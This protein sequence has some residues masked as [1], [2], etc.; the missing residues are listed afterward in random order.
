MST[1]NQHNG[2]RKIIGGVLWNAVQ[3]L[4][5]QAFSIIIRLVLAKLLFPEE[6]GIVGMALVFTNLVQMLNDIG[7][8][9]ALIQKK[10]AELRDTHYHTAFWTGIVWCLCLFLLMWVVVAPFAAKLYQEPLLLV[11]IPVMSTGILV[12]PVNLIQ[13]AQ[14]SRKMD[15]RKTAAIQ[16]LATI[17]AGAVSLVLAYGGAGIW[18]LVF[19]TVAPYFIAFPMFLA[20][21]RWKPR[22][23]WKKKEFK[24]VFGFGLFTTG[25]SL[26]GYAMN[27]ADYFFIGKFSDARLLGIYTLAFMLT[28]TFRSKLMTVMNNVMYPVYSNLQENPSAI[29]KYYLKVVEYNSLAVYPVMLCFIIYGEPLIA[30]FFGQKWMEAVLPLKILSGAVMVHML[31]N[32]NTVLIRGMGKPGLEMKLQLVKTCLFIPCIICGIY[33]N[34]IIGA[35]WAVLINKFIAVLIAQYTFNRLL[36]IKMTTRDIL[37]CV[38]TPVTATA[39]AAIVSIVLGHSG[40]HYIA[41]GLVLIAVYGTVV[42]L[43]KKDELLKQLEDLKT[44]KKVKYNEP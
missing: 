26:A 36:T 42:W 37:E 11:I 7:I 30:G 13:Q 44:I 15:F 22:M 2:K 35:A 24:E 29:K 8:S 18:S 6:F 23:V 1:S 31:V 34:G 27:N 43:L 5:N 3:M 9:A 19:N 14:L 4:V 20:A 25:T 12:S 16:S 38:K 10:E 40:I 32:S 17:L 41:G 21:T 39:A 33:Y 28:D